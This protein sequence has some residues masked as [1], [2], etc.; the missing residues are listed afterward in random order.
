VR[1]AFGH[2]KTIAVEKDGQALLLK[3]NIG[4]EE[5]VVDVTDRDKFFAAAKTRQWDREHNHN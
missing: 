3:A 4:Q 1:D 5:R 2:L